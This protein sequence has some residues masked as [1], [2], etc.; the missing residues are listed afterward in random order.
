M[1]NG[2][3]IIV[4]D[5]EP[6][7]LE[8]LADVLNEEG[9][10]LESSD[11]ADAALQKMRTQHFDLLLTDIAMPGMDGIALIREAKRLQPDLIPIVM[12]GNATLDTARAAVKS[13]AFDY[14]LK[15]FD[16]AEIRKAVIGALER[17]R[18]LDENAR[19]R[20]LGELFTISET[21][22]SLRDERTLLE[23][24]LKSALAK[25]GATRGSIMLRDQDGGT[26]SIA[27]SVGLPD[28]LK[29]SVRVKLGEGISGWVAQEG[30]PLLIADVERDDQFRNSS[31]KLPD[32]SFV[33]VPI[34]MHED[35]G[36]S[37]PVKSSK[38][39]LGVININKKLNGLPFTTS[40]L[41]TLSILA[42]QAAVSLENA[43]LFSSLQE[44]YLMT[45]Q[46]LVLALEAKDAY[47]HGHS[48]R[49]TTICLRAA[50]RLGLNADELDSLRVAATLHDLGKIAVPEAVLNKPGPLTEAE[51]EVVRRHP[52]VGCEVL[53][54]VTFLHK[55]LPIIRR[56]H[57][58]Q[59][60]RGYPDGIS[61]DALSK[62]D[63]IIIV[64]DA[65]DAMASDRAYRRALTDEELESQLKSNVGTQFDPDTVSILLELHRN[66]EFHSLR[67][68]AKES[69]CIKTHLNA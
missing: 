51:W 55:V 36:V 27:T 6:E 21:I 35:E 1:G 68:Q 48:Q 61:S 66:G 28:E 54:P 65:Y 59:D 31:Q 69:S 9:Y 18:L 62:N 19:L 24:V 39:I 47:T 12:T 15:P 45:I 57:E 33:S 60:G 58:R 40:D 38:R 13:G 16:V 63:R 5:D 26:L 37:L 17:K 44:A 64:A 30:K 8:L 22:N 50:G 34:E 56:H 67:A 11:G 46:S 4:V 23:F 49:V 20:E 41:K 7:V 52:A 42:N 14:V 29:N 10:A 2:E 32:K 3:K 43:R 25:V 53:A